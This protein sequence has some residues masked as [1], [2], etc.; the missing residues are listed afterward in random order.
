MCDPSSSATETGV[1]V[2]ARLA[3]FLTFVAADV[4]GEV[5]AGG[6][7]EASGSASG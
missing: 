2:K 7:T 6:A 5:V 4:I 3:S 1:F